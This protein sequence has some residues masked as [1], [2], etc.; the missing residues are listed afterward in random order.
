MLMR[1]IL[2]IAFTAMPCMSFAF[3]DIFTY[4]NYLQDMKTAANSATS[5]MNQAEQ[6]QNQIQAIRYQAQNSGNL[7]NYQYSR[8]TQLMQQ[9]SQISNQGQSI[10]YS[11]ANIDQQFRTQYPN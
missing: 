7:S 3:G 10:S 8:L 6:I 9:M 11:A 2:I 5:L 4:L 1:K